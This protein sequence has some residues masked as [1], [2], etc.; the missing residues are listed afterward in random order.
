MLDVLELENKWSKYHFKKQ[1]PLYITSLIVVVLSGSASYLYL[2]RPDLLNTLFVHKSTT[3]APV[4]VK[5][6]Q[7]MPVVISQVN[8]AS[9][10]DTQNML[11]PSFTFLYNLEDQVINHNNAK[12]LAMASLNEKDG[13]LDSKEKPISKPKKKYKKKPK[14]TTAK[15]KVT[16]NKPVKKS[17][18]SKTV[19]VKKKIVAKPVLVQEVPDNNQ[20]QDDILVKVEHDQIS[21]D[22]LNSVIKRFNKQKKPALSLFIAKK[23]YE[24]GKYQEAYNYALITN[25]LNPNIEESIL[26]FSRSLVKLGQKESAVSTLQAYIRKSGSLKAKL[27]LSEIE[28]GNFT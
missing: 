7:V 5:E 13:D 27:L 2:K 24:L 20:D 22:E 18:P 23:Y 12:M 11:T 25:N 15:A 10:S 16:P 17:A 6:V 4:P 14:K 28:K 8:K 3:T 26:I 19:P 1:L 21:V 9:A